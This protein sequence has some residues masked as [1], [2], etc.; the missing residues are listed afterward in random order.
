LKPT[1]P[2]HGWLANLAIGVGITL[3]GIQ[4]LCEGLALLR[5]ESAAFGDN[6]LFPTALAFFGLF[7][8]LVGLSVGVGGGRSPLGGRKIRMRGTKE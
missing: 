6:P 1:G 2:A 8:I 3:F 7:V 4:N 5:A